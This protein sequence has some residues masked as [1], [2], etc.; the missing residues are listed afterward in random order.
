[1]RFFPVLANF[2]AHFFIPAT[3]L[4]AMSGLVKAEECEPGWNDFS[5][6]GQIGLA[7]GAVRAMVE[8]QGDLIVGGQLDTAGGQQINHIARWDG[9]EW[10]VLESGGQVGVGGS[11][12]AGGPA[13]NALVVWNDNLIV[14]GPFQTAGG[15]VMNRIAR[16]DGESWHPI[17]TL[18]G[19]GQEVIGV[20]SSN[21][22]SINDLLVLDDDLIVGG[23]FETAGGVTVNNIA[24]RVGSNWLPFEYEDEIGLHLRVHSL[25]TWQGD[26]VVGGQFHV[27]NAQ[28]YNRIARWDGAGWRRFV[29]GGQAGVE[30][31][32]AQLRVQAML[33]YDGSL[34]IGGNF[35]TAGGQD[36]NLIARWDGEQW[37]AL[38]VDGV[39]GVSGPSSPRVNALVEFEG[40]LVIGGSFTEAGGETMN[41]IA[42]WDGGSWHPFVSGPDIGMQT[43]VD[44][45]KARDD[46]LLAGG[47]FNEAGGEE[48]RR[49]AS[50]DGCR[51]DDSDPIFRSNFEVSE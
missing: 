25:S 31:L 18:D 17:I 48:V 7:G 28:S 6:G 2:P 49:L 24:R 37:Q 22:R 36:A 20:G 32:A 16:W 47:V 19:Q 30:G 29:S 41:H 38:E 21:N 43:R 45:L 4:L 33:E 10:H 14:A 27:I 1:M 26:L 11:S 8:F 5:S 46:V 13:V 3:A 44:S 9:A 35:D 34:Y 50:W 42:R 23:F 51:D 12:T 40:D 39:A 15:Q